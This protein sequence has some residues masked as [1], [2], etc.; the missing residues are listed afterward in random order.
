MK[1]DAVFKAKWFNMKKQ[2][3][4][5]W[6]GEDTVAG[7]LSNRRAPLR[8]AKA[9][10]QL[11]L[12]RLKGQPGLEAEKLMLSNAER[13]GALWGAMVGPELRVPTCPGAHSHYETT[14][15]TTEIILIWNQSAH[16]KIYIIYTLL[17]G[18]FRAQGKKIKPYSFRAQIMNRC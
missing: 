1:N 16:S 8:L 9:M 2:R 6:L 13:R 3:V 15:T 14:V 18:A 11:Q 5:H 12:Y 10:L 7:S 4:G 17:S